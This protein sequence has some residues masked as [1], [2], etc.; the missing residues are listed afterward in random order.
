[1]KIKEKVSFIIRFKNEE[2]WIGHSIQSIIDH[3]ENP[4]IIVVDNNSTDNSMKII[5][6]FNNP[7]INCCIIKRININE[8]TPGLSLNKGI[9][10]CTNNIIL[11]MSAHCILKKINF[12]KIK[13][14]LEKY[15]AI[16]GKQIPIYY[17][18]KVNRNRYIWKNFGNKDF[19]N[20]YSNG[21][22]RYF[23]HNAF[24]FYNKDFLLKYPFDES[25][26]GKEDRYWVKDRISENKQILYDSELVCEHHYTGNGATW[27]DF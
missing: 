22:D 21:E 25:Y 20:Y 24:C 27:R 15:V 1:M 14:S 10:E 8:Y 4:E 9:N 17:G 5:N 6:L 11:I 12:T 19:V 2:R 23:L 3:F 7:K 13:N 16:W 26:I 18:K